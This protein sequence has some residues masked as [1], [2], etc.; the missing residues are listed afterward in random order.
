MLRRGQANLKPISVPIRFSTYDLNSEEEVR[1]RKRGTAL[2]SPLADVF[3]EVVLFSMDRAVSRYAKGAN[4][5]RLHDDFWIW[6][7]Q[8]E[9]V[10]AWHA[11]AE[12]NR[13]MG[14]EINKDKSGSVVISQ[15]KTVP[16][17]V[18]PHK[19]PA[20]LG[21]SVRNR[22]QFA[23]EPESLPSGNI[24]W[25]F[26]ILD[27]D[28][29][30][31][32]V[33]DSLFKKHVQELQLRLDSE[34][35]ILGYIKA[36]N[37]ISVRFFTSMLGKPANCLGLTHVNMVL[38]AFKRV[39]KILF[40]SGSV[41]E[42]LKGEINR[43]FNIQDIPDGFLYFPLALGGL[44]LHNPFIPYLQV[45]STIT[46]NPHSIMDEFFSRE[47]A[48][49]EQKKAMFERERL[50]KRK[51]GDF[52]TFEHYTRDREQ[53]SSLLLKAYEKLLEE[54]KPKVPK[55]EFEVDSKFLAELS[56]YQKGVLHLHGE[57]MVKRFGGLSVVEKRLLPMKLV[58]L[59]KQ[60][61][62]RW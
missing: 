30:S 48:V 15:N 13:V 10:K 46:Q 31:F 39:Q 59:S 45:R 47:K 36:W 20:T 42:H 14:L 34:K 58:Q 28:T 19:K 53:T 38:D 37:H 22:K 62:M 26:L 35:S 5:H 33:D 40:P 44:D 32:E 49:Y 6:G 2:S 8:D 9:C 51:K 21:N 41:T 23:E 18:A 11:V 56:S 54:P 29:R 7:S 17:A 60:R 61:R 1:I 52:M 25:G 16:S 57:E 4:L 24:A 3:S 12:F 55:L 50:A 27:A 43:R